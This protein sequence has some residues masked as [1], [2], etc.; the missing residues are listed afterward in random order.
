[1]D[2][3]TI[4]GFTATGF[5]IN[6]VSSIL[7]TATDNYVAWC[8]SAGAGIT[9]SN[10]NGTITSTVSVNTAS[11]FS[12]VTYAGTGAN[13]TTGHGL[14]GTPDLII[15]KARDDA[16]NWDIYHSALPYTSTLIFTTATTRSALHAAPTST[17]IP[18]TNSYTG[19]SASGK[20]MVA[21]CWKAVPGFSQFGS[22][23]G[24]GSSTD[25]PFVYT[26]FRPRMIMVKNTTDTSTDWQ[27]YDNARYTYNVNQ[28][29]I[30]PNSNVSEVSIGGGNFLDILSNGIKFRNNA[31][32]KNQSGSTFIYA[33]FA[34]APFGNINGTAR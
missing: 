21:Y 9:S 11:Q 30:R 29:Q 27:I 16:Y 1:V 26:G 18:V 2:T 19:G 5:T 22:Y 10:T 24:N 8:W 12:I 20:K 31:T 13:G 14:T 28:A 23:V 6:G 17:T 4:N 34:D 32:D 25:G 3:N 7:N 33:I 15:W